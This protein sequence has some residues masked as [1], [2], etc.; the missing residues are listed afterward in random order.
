MLPPSLGSGKSKRSDSLTYFLLRPPSDFL[1]THDISEAGSAS[2]FR[3]GQ[4]LICW[5]PQIQRSVG[6]VLEHGR[7]ASAAKTTFDTDLADDS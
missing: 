5:T 3:K 4:H 6:W 2:V 7:R 1:T